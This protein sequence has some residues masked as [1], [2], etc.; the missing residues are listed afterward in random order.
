MDAT[1]KISAKHLSRIGYV[2]IRQSTAY[3]VSSNTESTL[4]QYALRDRLV[5]LGWDACMIHTIDSD[6]GFSGKTS[7][8]REG[9]QQLMSDVANGLVGA[10]ACIEASRLSRCSGDWIRLIEICSMTD[11]LLLDTDGI[12]NPNDFNDRLLLGL[13]GTMSEA[14]LHFLQ[15]R[16][17]GGLLNKAKRGELKRYLPIG[18]EYDLDDRVVKTSNVQIRECIDQFFDLFRTL[19]TGYAVVNYYAENDMTFPLRIRRKGH[20]G[21]VQWESLNE[22]RAIAMLHNPFYTGAY[23]YGRTQ[24]KW[25]PG[26]KKR[27]VPVPEEE[28]H[29][30]IPDHHEAYITQEE[31]KTNQS[32]LQENSQQF[33]ETGKHTAPRE[34]TALIQGICYCGKCGAKMYSQYSFRHATG[35]LFPKYVCGSKRTNGPDG[36]H[37]I[38]PADR[39]DAAISDLVVR[40]LSPEAI[41]LTLDVQGEVQRRRQEHN[42]YFELQ[43]EKVKHE[44]DMARLRYMSV[45]P[46]NRLVALELEANWNKKLRELD[47]ARK[48]LEEETEKNQVS[49]KEE[50]ETAAR[51]ISESFGEI[52]N[53]PGLKNEDRKRIVRYL[54]R[55]VTIKRTEHYTVVVQICFQGGATEEIE[56]SIAKPRYKEIET[57]KDVIEF[58]EKEA[59]NHPYTQL[60]R[61]L[62]E[63]GYSRQCRRPFTP[64]NIHRIMKAYGIKSMKQRYLDRGWLTLYE[65]ADRIGITP[66][67]LKYRIKNGKYDGDFVVVEDRG[68]M[69]FSP[70]SVK[71]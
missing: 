52:W 4:C 67:G 28:W 39:V 18:Y 22:D 48:K 25:V 44:E 12:Y 23:T 42:R 45:D 70:K 36:C 3:Q 8:A 30:Y 43:L 49:T 37:E 66:Q 58:L 60:A 34:G 5:A 71:D 27:Q 26:G 41:A 2:Y 6:L 54:I 1:T 61:M 55:D 59:E 16:M 63:Q 62:N 11:T 13:K 64:K 47:S 51:Q 65:T 10:I 53:A 40:R 56:V 38:I 68:T 69:L 24:V 19:K 7:D 14:E 29:V 46:T 32:I 21:E 35:R 50:L 33:K 17:R 31:F 9:F 20:A 57:P 15:E